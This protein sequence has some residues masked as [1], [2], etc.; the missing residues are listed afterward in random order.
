MAND[1]QV[2]TI[3]HESGRLDAVLSQF[4]SAYTRSQLAN[5]IKQGQI[6]VNGQTVKP[7]YKVSEGDRISVEPPAPVSTELEPENIPLDIV[8]EDED[9]LV[10]NKPQGMVVHPAPG[11][12]DHTLVNAL[13]YHSPLS[14]ING[15]FRPGIVHRIDR[16]T[17]GLLMVAKNDKAH[18]ALSAQLKE[19]KNQRIYYALVKGD[20]K[21]DRGTIEA[22]LGR[23]PVDRK[24]QAVV[25][26][27]REAI[28][29][30]EVVQRYLGY[31]LLK[32]R[33][34]TGRTHQI[35]VHMAYIGHPVVGDSLYNRQPNLPGVKLA[36]Q[37]LHAKTLS[38]QQPSTGK[39]ML[40]DSDLPDYFKEALG[41]LTPMIT[42]KGERK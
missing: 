27:G 21:E 22:P 19:H 34:E 32:V 11:H 20:F 33:L 28:T 30:F 14:S 37:L 35:R 38:L 4:D 42:V 16:D 18:Q 39:E 5:W 23:H 24:R 15:E 31:T 10:V 2:F 3:Q 7:S 17:S 36:G 29:H 40:F 8:Y 9:L 26:G 25:E 41:T 6:L 1:A 12:A 13:L